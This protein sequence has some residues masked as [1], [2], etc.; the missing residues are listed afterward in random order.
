VRPY[1]W[2]ITSGALPAGLS[3]DASA[4]SVS[5]ITTNKG[6]FSFVVTI[7]DHA[8]ST[9]GKAFQLNVVGADSVPQVDSV[10]YKS[11]GRKLI[12]RGQNFDPAAVLFIDESQGSARVAGSDQITAKPIELTSGQHTVRVVNPNGASSNTLAF[13]VN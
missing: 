13:N 4:G 10:K 5:G 1:A 8:G 2:A 7:T 12:V 9:N 6:S 11:S 3:L